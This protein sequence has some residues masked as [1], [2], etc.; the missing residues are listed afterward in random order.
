ASERSP[1]AERVTRQLPDE[2]GGLI[3]ADGAAT[4]VRSVGKG[5]PVLVLH[6][7]PGFDH[8]YL[9]GPLATLASRRRLIFYDQSGSGRTP[10]AAGGAILP[11]MIRQAQ[12]MLR[13]V[14]EAEQGQFGVIAHSWGALVLA[15]AYADAGADKPPAPGEGALINPVALTRPEWDVAFHRLLARA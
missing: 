3:D 15:G 12:A 5:P 2:Q 1:P 7:G 4:F 14:A 6:G 9:Y 8:A 11:E 10:P 13:L